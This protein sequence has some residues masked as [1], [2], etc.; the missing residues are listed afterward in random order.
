MPSLHFSNPTRLRR[1]ERHAL[2]RGVRRRRAHTHS[3]AP[4]TVVTLRRIQP[5]IL[6]FRIFLDKKGAEIRQWWIAVEELI[7]KLRHG[8]TEGFEDHWREKLLAGYYNAVSEGLRVEDGE[9][10]SDNATTFNRCFGALKHFFDEYSDEFD[11]VSLDIV[12]LLK[13]DGVKIPR[14]DVGIWQEEWKRM[15]TKY[16]PFPGNQDYDYETIIARET[17]RGM[18]PKP[19]VAARRFMQHSGKEAFTVISKRRLSQSH[20]SADDRSESAIERKRLG[21]QAERARSKATVGVATA[22]EATAQDARATLEADTVTTDK[23]AV[24]ADDNIVIT[25]IAR[26]TTE[27]NQTLAK[28]SMLTTEQ[29]TSSGTTHKKGEDTKAPGSERMYA[30]FLLEHD[31]VAGLFFAKGIAELPAVK[32]ALETTLTGVKTN[33]EAKDGVLTDSA[34]ENEAFSDI[35]TKSVPVEAQEDQQAKREASE[36]PSADIQIRESEDKNARQ[37]D[38]DTQTKDE[39]AEK[40]QFEDEQEELRRDPPLFP[41]GWLE[42]SRYSFDEI[43]IF[44][45]VESIEMCN[46]RYFPI[47]HLATQLKDIFFDLDTDEAGCHYFSVPGISSVP[48]LGPTKTMQEIIE[49]DSGP[50]VV[51]VDP[52]FHAV[53][54]KEEEERL[55]RAEEMRKDKER[56]NE[57]NAEAAPGAATV[58]AETEG[59]AEKAHDFRCPCVVDVVN[60]VLG[61]FMLVF[62]CV[63][64]LARLRNLGSGTDPTGALS[65]I[66]ENG[67]DDDADSTVD[68]K[69]RKATRTAKTM[70]AAEELLSTDDYEPAE[71][72]AWT[73]LPVQGVNDLEHTKGSKAGPDGEA[74]AAAASVDDP[75]LDTRELTQEML[76]NGLKP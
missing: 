76:D 40:T 31:L 34:S 3:F 66:A 55:A 22:E 5:T 20:I 74:V 11:N 13:V 28:D 6:N 10:Q 61:M 70:A 50:R 27:W 26:V 60:W 51:F 49:R 46:D 2:S 44:D 19:S 23:N 9:I 71:S 33:N 37:Q 72:E 65:I 35:P 7:W 54:L 8:P 1:R 15:T 43:Q 16:S 18:G 64:G 56:Q 41:D 68:L 73:I 38:S 21:K 52:S 14:P 24:T 29:P 4:R 59:N 12:T 42:Q 36:A 63:I 53:E 75:A 58:D 30:N 25:G 45:Y 57:E 69:L 39:D 62:N 48:Q 67:N 32:Q 17:R 47:V